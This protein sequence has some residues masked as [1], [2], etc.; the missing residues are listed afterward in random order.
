MPRL[1]FRTDSA[2]HSTGPLS[3]IRVLDLSS[4]GPATRCTSVLAD[5][6]ASVVKVGSRLRSPG[7]RSN[8][9]STPTAATGAL[10][11]CN[12]HLRADGGRVAFLALAARA[13]VIVE[14][15]RPGVVDRLG[16]GYEAVRSTN[17]GV[18]Y[19]ARTSGF[20]QDDPM[21]PVRV[22]ISTT[23]AWAAFWPR[24]NPR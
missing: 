17:P 18:I 2:A 14:S 12:L 3:G 15:F 1:F 16:I 22:T 13:D 21:P 5:Y 7:Y 8:R 9:P 20:G 10:I 11:A 6:G 24:A 19:P 4:V 23:S